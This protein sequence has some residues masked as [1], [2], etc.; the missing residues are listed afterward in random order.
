[1]V[2]PEMVKH[3]EVRVPNSNIANKS[4]RRKGE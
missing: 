1:M 2:K 4:K 3:I